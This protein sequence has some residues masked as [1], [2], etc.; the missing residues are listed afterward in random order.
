ME[1]GRSRPHCGEG[2]ESAQ[3]ND[4]LEVR[5]EIEIEIKSG[6]EIEID[7]EVGVKIDI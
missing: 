1:G 4:A 2:G 7:I 5:V 3:E 6:I